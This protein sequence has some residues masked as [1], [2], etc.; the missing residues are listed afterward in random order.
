MVLFMPP[1]SS[2][3]GDKCLPGL[4]SLEGR[5][6]GQGPGRRQG[7][8]PAPQWGG[9]HIQGPRDPGGEGRHQHSEWARSGEDLLAALIWETREGA[10]EG[11]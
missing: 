7:L 6:L 4:S 3:R 11:I 10:S 2:Y 8:Q 9:T 1:C 5:S